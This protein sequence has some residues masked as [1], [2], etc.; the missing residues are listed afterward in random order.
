MIG[1]EYLINLQNFKHLLQTNQRVGLGW[2]TLHLRMARE[3]FLVTTSSLWC[4]IITDT[5]HSDTPAID[6]GAKVALIFVGT[7]SGTLDV[8][9]MK[10]K[11]E[12]VN[13]PQDVMRTR[14]APLS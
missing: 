3:M 8:H 6:N 1:F 9:G 2:L 13:T 11:S 7:T 12:F 10:I 5:I 14:G 4:F